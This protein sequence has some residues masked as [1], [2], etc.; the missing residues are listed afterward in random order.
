MSDDSNRRLGRGLAALIGDLDVPSDG[1][2][3]S[4]YAVSTDADKAPSADRTV[5]V[6]QISANPNN[7]RRQFDETEIEELAASLRTHGLVQPILVRPVQDGYQIVA[8]ERR[9]RAAQKARLDR[10]PVVVREIDDV[11]ALEL[12]IVENVQRSDLNAI[13]EARGY[14][15]LIDHHG[16]SQAD[17]GRTIGKSRSHVANTLRLLNLPDG[18][19]RLVEDGSLSA[20]HAR[21]ILMAPHPEAMAARVID[22]GLSVRETERLVGEANAPKPERPSRSNDD[23]DV[24]DVE[25]RII[26]AIGL[27]TK[28]AAKPD[29]SGQVTIR[30]GSLEQLDSLLQRLERSP[31]S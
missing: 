28:L 5:P 19:L 24:R 17:L 4:G 18:V 3:R 2:T 6:E 14:G 31:G 7:P 1:A 10:V 25:R 27:K 11:T 8:G 13:E 23:S 29:G 30:Y 26:D 20:G 16:Y 15:Q 12:A 22:G 21:A 9:W